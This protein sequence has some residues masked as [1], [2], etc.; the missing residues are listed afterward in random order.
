MWPLMDGYQKQNKQ[1]VALQLSFLATETYRQQTLTLIHKNT[2]TL[3]CDTG[4]SK[5][6]LAKNVWHFSTHPVVKNLM[7]KAVRYTE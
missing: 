7:F 6:A 1:P 5:Y 3:G 2:I 4:P